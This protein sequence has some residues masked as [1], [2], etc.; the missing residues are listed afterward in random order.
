MSEFYCS[1]HYAWVPYVSSMFDDSTCEDNVPVWWVYKLLASIHVAN[2]IVSNHTSRGSTPREVHRA[3]TTGLIR[4]RVAQGT[5]EELSC[6][7]EMKERMC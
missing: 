1:F 7:S 5:L 4:S 6:V 2:V 3:L